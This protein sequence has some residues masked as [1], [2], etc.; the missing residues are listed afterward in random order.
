MRAAIAAL[1]LASS[2][3]LLAGPPE[4]HHP[5]CLTGN[6]LSLPAVRFAE[7]RPVRLSWFD[8]PG[9]ARD[10]V[11]VVPIDT[12]DEDWGPYW[13]YTQG[14][15]EGGYVA[16][17]LPAGDYE[18]RLY[19]DWPAGGFQ[20][21]DR[22]RFSVLPGPPVAPVQPAV[23]S[24][25]LWLP[26]ARFRAGEPARVGW[27]CPHGH[28]QDWITVVKP[29]TPAEEWGA[30]MFTDGRKEGIFSVPLLA[31]GIYEARFYKDWPQGGFEITDRLR[32][33][34]GTLEM[35]R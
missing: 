32:F 6:H 5:G 8:T 27:R 29:D 28:A 34:V 1:V 12:P 22:L 20:V 16:E 9:N 3:V 13:T 26:A 18:A 21:V 23:K 4:R 25:I 7:G 35:A 10:W 11:S 24:K 33:E 19:L 2:A 17:Q 31:P 30:W 15:V 14:R